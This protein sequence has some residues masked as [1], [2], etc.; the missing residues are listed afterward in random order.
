[1]S[2]APALIREGSGETCEVE[3]AK[4]GNYGPRGRHWCAFVQSMPEATKRSP[5]YFRTT[6]SEKKGLQNCKPLFC[7]VAGTGFEPV[8]FG[9]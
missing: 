7:L 9:L 3:H 8:T 2:D 5:F 4:S 1:M 6:A